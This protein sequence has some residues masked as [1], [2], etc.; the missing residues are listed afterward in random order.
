MKFKRNIGIT[1]VCI[2][3]GVMLA[4][5]YRGV[6]NHKKAESLDNKTMSELKEVIIDAQNR[7]EEL[8]NRN[9]ELLSEI[10]EYETKRGNDDAIK[11]ELDRAR[12]IAG[13][14]DVKG[15]GVIV[16]VDDNGPVKV[17]DMSLL[18]L[19]NELRASDA[20]A[21]SINDERIVAMSEV[22]KAGSYIMINGKQMRAPYVVKAIADPERMEHTLKMI[23]GMSERLQEY[24]FLKVDIK[25]SDD[26]FI[27]KVSD[28]G[29][30]VKTDLLKPSQK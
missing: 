13:L 19:L 21:I 5:Q 30:M 12:K 3:L 6:S 23:G 18:E 28:S 27:P 14:V 25:K 10:Q 4:L 29:P 2:L 24:Y 7:N 17:D 1:L 16:T 9:N 11:L 26:I 22:R 15:K 8:R 20:Q